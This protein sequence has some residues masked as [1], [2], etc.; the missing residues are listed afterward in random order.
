VTDAAWVKRAWGRYLVL[1]RGPG[2]L[3]KALEFEPG[4]K[5]SLQR[6]VGRSEVF[7]VSKGNGKL[8][9]GLDD[10]KMFQGVIVHVF[11]GEWHR[12]EAGPEGMT[13]TEVWFGEDL[14]EDDIVRA[15]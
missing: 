2:F 1:S 7:S 14:R 13:L 11:S 3:V 10:A 4:G 9:V 12:L 15:E 6:H 8:T 5:T